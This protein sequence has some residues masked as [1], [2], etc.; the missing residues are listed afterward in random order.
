MTAVSSNFD[1]GM[2][3]RPTLSLSREPGPK[4]DPGVEAGRPAVVKIPGSVPALLGVGLRAPPGASE[5]R[6]LG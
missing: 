6:P 4:P 3:T 1:T 2:Q 5:Q